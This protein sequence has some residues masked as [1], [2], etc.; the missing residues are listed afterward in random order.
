MFR[1]I[2]GIFRNILK[3]AFRNTG[4]A[5]SHRCF[6]RSVG[7]CV[8]GFVEPVAVTDLI[9]GG[10]RGPTPGPVR[11]PTPAVPLAPVLARALA[12]A[13]AQ[14]IVPAL[15]LALALIFGKGGVLRWDATCASP[16][17]PAGRPLSCVI[18]LSDT[19]AAN[20][21]Q[22]LGGAANASSVFPPVTKKVA[23]LSRVED[24]RRAELVVR[25]FENAVGNPEP[26]Q[27]KM[28]EPR[29]FGWSGRFF[30]MKE[31][32]E[33]GKAGL[34][35]SPEW[36]M[37]ETTESGSLQLNESLGPADPDDSPGIR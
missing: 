15:A 22:E 30:N 24:R 25:A 14:A 37:H 27:D 32:Q 2:A 3:T 34:N 6:Q 10:C 11:A 19:G 33:A 4:L 29:M 9:G 12:P 16:V 35:G 26:P 21:V 8:T 18:R 13:L 31:L 20:Q 1:N 7:C 36:D 23:L 28:H 5:W 17:S